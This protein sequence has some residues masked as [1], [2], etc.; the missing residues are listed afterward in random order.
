MT[1][2]LLPTPSEVA[3]VFPRLAFQEQGRYRAAALH[4]RRV[5]PGPVGELIHRELTAYADFGYRFSND[6]L[7]P[8]LAAAVLAI[9]SDPGNVGPAPPFGM[10]PPPRLCLRP[11]AG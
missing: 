7:V 1:S 6:G 4:A 10:P 8:R 5:V 2:T 3:G 9:E 11:T